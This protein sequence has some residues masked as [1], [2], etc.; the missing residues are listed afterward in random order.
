MALR[1]ALGLGARRGRGCRRWDRALAALCLL[2]R[3]LSIAAGRVLGALDVVTASVC[4]G[5]TILRRTRTTTPTSTTTPATRLAVWSEGRTRLA[6]SCSFGACCAL[7]T[8]RRAQGIRDSAGRRLRARACRCAGAAATSATT[9]A[10]RLTVGPERRATLTALYRPTVFGAQRLTI[11]TCLLRPA[12]RTLMRALPT[13]TTAG[14]STRAP[15]WPPAGATTA[16]GPTTGAT[17]PATAAG[18]ATWAATTAIIAALL[19]RF[20]PAI[21]LHR[22]H[23]ERS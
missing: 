21:F 22:I 23:R 10:T 6:R 13:G 4:S 19:E 3:T 14:P 15:T 16:T 5:L 18:T 17:T 2:R 20:A 7:G 9:T 12:W 8:L 1:L 11:G